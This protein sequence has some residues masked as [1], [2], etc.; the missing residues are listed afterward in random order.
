MINNWFDPE[1]FMADVSPKRVTIT[2][3]AS[4]WSNNTQTKTVQGISA[5]EEDQLIQPVP[6]TT[7]QAAYYA[8]GI[9]CTGQ[10]ANQ[11]TFTCQTVPT[12]DLTVY[13]TIQGVSV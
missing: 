1:F 10:A 8:A 2:L 7:S 9:L 12:E 4:G 5:D 11:L 13:I 3:T 6:K